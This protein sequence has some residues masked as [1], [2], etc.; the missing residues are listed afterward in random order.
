VPGAFMS[1]LG[2]SLLNEIVLREDI[3]Q[4]DKI[5]NV[6]RERIRLS[7]SSG[8]MKTDISDGM[9]ISVVVL[10]TLTETLYFA[11]AYNPLLICREGKMIVHEADRMPVGKHFS[12]PVPFTLKQEKLIAGDR[13]FLFTDGFKDQFGGENNRKFSLAKFKDL[14]IDTDNLP[15]E[16]ISGRIEETFDSW[17]KDNEQIDDVLIIGIGV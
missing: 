1:M 14:V 6:L 7:L 8:K 4:P 2:I 11:G 13:Y 9:D 15:F 17:K 16:K 5:L 3:T 10:N 12:D